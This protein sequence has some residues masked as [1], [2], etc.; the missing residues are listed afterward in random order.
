MTTRAPSIANT[1]RRQSISERRR[2]RIRL[3][4][5]KTGDDQLFNRSN[6]STLDVDMSNIQL[7]LLMLLIF[8]TLLIC[9][10]LEMILPPATCPYTRLH[11]TIDFDL[12]FLSMPTQAHGAA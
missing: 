11:L 4:I 2:V 12:F 10:A 9:P 5:A 1:P 8:T 3:C 6:P 7:P